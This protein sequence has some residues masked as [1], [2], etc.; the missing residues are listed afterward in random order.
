MSRRATPWSRRGA[1]AA[2]GVLA[3]SLQVHGASAGTL[4][5]FGADEVRRILRHG[6]W[7][8][9]RA[10]D[11][12]NAAA[13][14]GA[15]IA[16][17]ERLF[18]DGRLSIDGALSCASCHRPAQAFTDGRARSLGRARAQPARLAPPEAVESSGQAASIQEPL[19]RN[20]PSLWNAVHE[21]WYGWD[22]AAD[23]LW[24][25]SIRPLLDAREMASNAAHV[26]R[27]IAGD[28][29]L[30][31]RYR[32]AFAAAPLDD[33]T[34]L[35][36]AAKAI[37]AFVGTLVSGRTPFDDFRA[38]LARGDTRAAARYPLPAQRGLRLFVGRGRCQLCH[39]GPLFSNGEFGD[40]GLPFF[41]RP[42]MVD[43]GRHGGIATLRASSYNLLSRWS[44]ARGDA[45]AKTRHV[46]SQHR[47]FG[48]F[49]V[50]GLR[51][52]AHSA[53]YMHDGQLATL[54]DVV[55]HYSNLNLDR[56]HADGERILQ[57]LHLSDGERADLLAFL[58][59]LSDPKALRWQASP[60]AA[61]KGNP[62]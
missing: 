22:G 10:L 49:K 32:R 52:V 15:A 5:D 7:P 47:N 17:G 19:D 28:A 12:G 14:R 55:E 43:P 8:P 54:A 40:T 23:S 58:H 37:G 31:C 35:V 3:W 11:A 51:N 4:L 16:L 36:N 30:S 57:P 21:R 39:L 42:G 56:L 60:R 25:Q 33:E 38:A 20:A 45:A 34:T 48:E 1:W 46:Q 61:C 9:P 24:S 27:T 62:R 50:P 26:R 6:P 44:D 59:S 13:G 29:E 2:A 18:F 41:S 53:P